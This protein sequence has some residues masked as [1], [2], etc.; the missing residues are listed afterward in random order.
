[1]L[2]GSEDRVVMK[3]LD[4]RAGHRILAMIQDRR[5]HDTDPDDDSAETTPRTRQPG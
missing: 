2:E 3:R 4:T 5:R 1:M